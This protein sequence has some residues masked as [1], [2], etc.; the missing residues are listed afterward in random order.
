MLVPEIESCDEWTERY[1]RSPKYIK[2][3][4][5]KP[6]KTIHKYLLTHYNTS[7]KKE[8]CIRVDMNSVNDSA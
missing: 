3:S 7:N 5:N 8:D 2:I 1:T 4:K 6:Y